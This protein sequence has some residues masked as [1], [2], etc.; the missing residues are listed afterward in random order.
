MS[1][2]CSAFAIAVELSLRTFSAAATFTGAAIFALISDIAARSGSAS[3]AISS[4]SSRDSFR[5]SWSLMSTPF[6]RLVRAG[7]L[8]AAS[9]LATGG[10]QLRGALA[11]VPG[12]HGVHVRSEVDPSAFAPE[13]LA[14]DPVELHEGLLSALAG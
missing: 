6:R 10:L 13:R 2:V 14:D 3:P 8:A 9:G 5:C 7:A 12:N 11:E 1:A 4:S